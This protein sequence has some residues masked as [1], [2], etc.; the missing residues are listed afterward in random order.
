MADELQ[1]LDE[2]YALDPSSI[3][4]YRRD[5]HVLL[6]GLASRSEAA[7]YR[8][9]IG[10]AVRR[11][12]HEQ[13]PLGERDTY[14]KAFLQTGN[15]WTRD[16]AVEKFV[17]SRRFAQVAAELM[18]VSGVRV[19]H[20]QALYKEAGGGFTPWHQ[21]QY[22][23]PFEGDGC[24]TLWMPLI[25]LDAQTGIMQFATGSHRGGFAGHLPIGD[26][27]EQT[28]AEHVENRGYPIG[29]AE[30]MSAG[31]ATFHSGWT[32]HR[33]SP[34]LSSQMREV[35][36]IIYFTDGMRASHPD[37][38]ARWSDLR[39]CLPGVEPGELAV[40]PMNPLVYTREA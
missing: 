27:S 28:L 14:G 40:S 2:P 21:D 4:Q 31:D 34:N 16:A 15:L 23:W 26:H 18:G 25:D 6:R 30:L 29:G 24:I 36:T 32:L 8:P 33:A 13:R 35:M 10:E 11:F 39:A 7:C 22:Y 19:Y 3:A 17:K 38:E 5:G 20:D 37:N 12:N 9:V 1:S